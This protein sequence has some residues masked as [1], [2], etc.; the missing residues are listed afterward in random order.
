M[1]K[2]REL[3]KQ[4]RVPMPP[5]KQVH[6]DKRLKRNKKADLWKKDLTLP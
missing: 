2:N 4:I 1:K 3:L 5:P 6:K